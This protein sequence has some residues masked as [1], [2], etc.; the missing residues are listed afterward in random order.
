MLDL[1]FQIF[2]KEAST[3]IRHPSLQVT[4]PEEQVNE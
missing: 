4:T 2:L 1:P 3:R